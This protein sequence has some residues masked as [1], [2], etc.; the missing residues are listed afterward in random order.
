MR[1]YTGNVAN[2]TFK[3]LEAFCGMMCGCIALKF[4]KFRSKGSKNAIKMNV[5]LQLDIRQNF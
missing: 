5:Y 2:C 4:S 3:Y 1:T